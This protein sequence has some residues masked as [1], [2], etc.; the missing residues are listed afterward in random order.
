MS[1]YKRGN[2]WWMDVYVG[3][4]NR[5]VRKST[6]TSDKVKARLIEQSAMSLN[7]GITDRQ[8][9]MMIIDAV[10][11]EHHSGLEVKDLPE[12]Y[13][14]AFEEGG[15]ELLPR[16]LTGRVHL[17]SVLA[18]WCHDHTHVRFVSEIDGEVAWQFASFVS[19]GNS[20]KT[21]NNK[22]GHLRT[23]WKLLITR[24]KA[25]DNP[26]TLARVQRR[27][28]E[29]KHG[30]AFTEDECARILEAC[31]KWGHEWPEVFTVAMY[32]GLRMG[33]VV[34]LTWDQV[35]TA[36]RM[37][38]IKPSKTRR[39]GI[40]VNIPMHAR[41]HDIISRVEHASEYVF[42]WRKRR[43]GIN[44]PVKGDC[45]FSQ[46]LKDAG[47]VAGDGEKISFHCARHTMVTNL[48]AAGVA[49]DVRMQMTG[50]TNAATHAIYTHDDTSSRDAIEKLK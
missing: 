25:K 27:P 2:V 45:K 3:A 32:T 49:P 18:Q 13:H 48:A 17:L 35:D 33:D 4:E 6:G 47:I 1:I 5:R 40:E 41:V 28:D 43:Q 30:R 9:A 7:R 36:E 39:H 24:G 15:S 8:R 12:F 16:E 37:I 34:S 21:R 22:V 20:A 23:A 46:I 38:R 31:R 50:H 10:M 14:K 42:P 29:E 11:P 44:N 26:W 19:K